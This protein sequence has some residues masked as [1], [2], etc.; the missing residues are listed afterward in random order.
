M[1][2]IAVCNQ[3]GGVGKTTVAINLGAALAE[4]GQ[5]TLL[6][7]L[8]PQGHLTEGLGLAEAAEPATLAGLL[9]GKWDGGLA[10]LVVPVGERLDAV[11]ASV[12]LFLAEAGL[13]LARGREHKLARALEPLRG[14]YD[15]CLIDCPPTLGQL[16]DNAL[17]AAGEVLVPIQAED[18]AL[19]AL[20]LLVDQVR[21]LEEGLSVR[22]ALVG[23][24]ANQVDDTRVAKRTLATLAEAV[25]VP[26]LAELRR[27]VALKEAWAQGRSILDAEPTGDTADAFRALAGRLVDGARP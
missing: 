5:R 26:V 6:V 1:R 4:R 25:P 10:E 16:T 11:P 13:V 18:T 19:R 7:D 23:L 20:E 14:A 15:Y 3:K 24:V 27:R 22:V 17:V 9:L 12:D 21:S 8:D 2:T